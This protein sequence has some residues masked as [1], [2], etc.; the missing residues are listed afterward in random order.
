VTIQE[1]AR[2][3][4]TVQDAVNLSGV[5][6]SF[7]EIVTE[8][9]W[10][11]ARKQGKGTDFVNRHPIV[12]LFLSKLA[13]LNGTDCLCTHCLAR[14]SDANRECESIAQEEVQS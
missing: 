11:E 1:A 9:I 7:S 10:P 2:T 13:S 12:T 5:L 4:I 8:V 6:H 14:F 3:A